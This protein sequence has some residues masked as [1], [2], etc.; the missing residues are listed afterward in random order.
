M[1]VFAAYGEYADHEVGRLVQA[2]EDLGQMD[3]TLIF[4][5]LGDNGAS[6]EGG[7][8]GLFNEMTYFNGVH[9]NVEDIL[10]HYDELGGPMSYN[11]YAAGWAVAG[12]T[13][14][15]WTKQ[16]AS[17]YGGTR[18]GM[19]VHWPSRIKAQGEAAVAVASRH[20][21]RADDPGGGRSARAE[22]RQWD[23]SDADRGREPGLH[24]R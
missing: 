15:T 14:F 4:Y 3:N 21:H 18:N 16:V 7:M 20:R 10:K 17:S 11:H 19:V 22:G 13:P 8:N 1:E 9:E 5:I 12:D 24:V 2:I 6:A 23:S